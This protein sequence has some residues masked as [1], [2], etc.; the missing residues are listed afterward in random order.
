MGYTL[1]RGD[2][3]APPYDVYIA[4]KT[5]CSCKDFAEKQTSASRSKLTANCKHI[6]YVLVCL[7]VNKDD[8]TLQLSSFNDNQVNII[9]KLEEKWV[10]KNG[11]KEV[12]LRVT[13]KDESTSLRLNRYTE[14]F[15][16][17]KELK[18][19]PACEWKATY[20]AKPGG[21]RGKPHMCTTSRQ[22]SHYME[23]TALCVQLKLTVI[24]PLTIESG[25]VKTKSY[26][27]DENLRYFCPNRECITFPK[28]TVSNTAFSNF[29]K[30][31]DI[32][33]DDRLSEEEK[34]TI[35]KL[36]E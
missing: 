14:L 30:P 23:K 12:V 7:G 32:L 10:T 3:S 2:N 9:K 34:I 20:Y 21:K 6:V 5:K 24:K 33:L 26:K 18:K 11:V 22:P 28:S 13:A 8:A 17:Q 25:G 1:Y 15:S 4:G 16:A 35:Q 19:G 27:I 29:E 31:K 36:T